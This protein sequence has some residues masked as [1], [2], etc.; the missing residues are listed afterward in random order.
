MFL[1]LTKML[2]GLGSGHKD[3]EVIDLKNSALKCQKLPNFPDV[4]NNVVSLLDADKN[5]V[6]CGGAGRVNKCT[7]YT[8]V[9][10]QSYSFM[11]EARYY[12]AAVP[13]MHGKLF[14]NF[15]WTRLERIPCSALL[16]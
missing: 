13:F 4:T 6:I 7:V 10:W 15:G 1:G 2:V 9:S 12:A 3:V 5:P 14:G 11:R 8:K 16:S